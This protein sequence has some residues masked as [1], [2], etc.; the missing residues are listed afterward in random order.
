[1]KSIVLFSNNRK[2]PYEND[3]E[4][5]PEMLPKKDEAI[6]QKTSYKRQTT[7]LTIHENKDLIFGEMSSGL[8]K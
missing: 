6:V 1:M 7:I 5:Y 4:T 3:K 8:M 2:R